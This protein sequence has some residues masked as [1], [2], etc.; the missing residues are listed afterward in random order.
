MASVLDSQLRFLH[1]SSPLPDTDFRR[2]PLG[3]LSVHLGFQSSLHVLFIMHDFTLSSLVLFPPF[4]TLCFL[5]IRDSFPSISTLY[6]DH[7]LITDLCSRQLP[8][9]SPPYPTVYHVLRAPRL[10]PVFLLII[11]LSKENIHS[12]HLR[13]TLYFKSDISKG[14][15]ALISSDANFTLMVY[16]PT[17][18]SLSI[19]SLVWLV[20]S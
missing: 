6:V 13:I 18:C 19:S 8:Q 20:N 16:D 5:H 9:G 3:S 11:V 10:P 17:A 7:W 2:P 12:P 1:P 15:S 4:L 14:L